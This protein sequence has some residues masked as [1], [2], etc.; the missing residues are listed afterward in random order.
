[1]INRDESMER[2]GIS[3]GVLVQSVLSKKVFM[4]SLTKE[5]TKQLAWQQQQQQH[6]VVIVSDGINGENLSA[7][8]SFSWRPFGKFNENCVRS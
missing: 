3:A 7:D 1:M 4:S 8:H 2:K 6:R 5:D